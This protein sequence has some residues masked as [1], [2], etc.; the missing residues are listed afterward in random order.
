MNFSRHFR[1]GRAEVN[2]RKSSDVDKP[3][4]VEFVDLIRMRMFEIRVKLEI[5]EHGLEEN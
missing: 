5:S 1:K 2:L 3:L 4:T